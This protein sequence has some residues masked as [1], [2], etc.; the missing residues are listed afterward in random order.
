MV[1]ITYVPTTTREMSSWRTSRPV[2]EY[3]KCTR[4]S[5]C[6]KFCPD[7]AIDLVDDPEIESPNERFKSLEAPKINLNYCKG[8]GICATECPFGAI[9][10][11]REEI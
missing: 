3:S 9:E 10:M 6:W 11:V 1:P 8:C 4:C 5:I 2:I 7:V